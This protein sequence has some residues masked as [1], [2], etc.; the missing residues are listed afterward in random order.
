MSSQQVV[1]VPE[2]PSLARAIFLQITPYL[3][4]GVIIVLVFYY[5]ASKVSGAIGGVIDGGGL[6]SRIPVVGGL[7]S[8]KNSVTNSIPVVGPTITQVS[9]LGGLL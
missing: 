5:A 2:Q 1:Y 4:L 7:F 8:L 6:L 9:T 3:I